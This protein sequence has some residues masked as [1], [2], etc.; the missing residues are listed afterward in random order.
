MLNDQ[1]NK[2]VKFPFKKDLFGTGK[3]WFYVRVPPI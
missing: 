2:L 1:F 3:A